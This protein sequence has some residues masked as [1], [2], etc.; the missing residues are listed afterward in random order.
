MSGEDGLEALAEAYE[1]AL[2]REKAGDAAGAAEGWRRVLALDPEDRGGAAVRLA[3]LGAEAAP[4]RAPP[5][6]VAELFDQH[7]EAFDD[8]LVRQL[9]YDAPAGLAALLRET[10]GAAAPAARALDL[11]CGTGLMAA[12]LEGLARAVDGVDLSEAMLAIADERGLYKELY[13]GDA[14][15][16]L[17]AEEAA[18]DGDARGGDAPAG[19]GAAG[20]SGGGDGDEHGGDDEDADAAAGP[21]D[22]ILA[23]DVLPYL[24]DLAPLAS[25]CARCLTPGGRLAL[26]SE[27]LPPEAI[28]PA[29]WTVGPHQ[30]FHHDPAYLARALEAEGFDIERLE[31]A[32]I[33]YNQGRPE[34][35]HLIVAR[36]SARAN[37]RRH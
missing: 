17:E 37:P 30:R 28:G 29:G 31:P 25:G 14:V 6:Y 19:D 21:W 36:L 3:A 16:F 5:A 35:G 24:G 26:S 12:A 9:G 32:V 8:I 23:A 27:T 11:G 7:A 20:A 4:D 10:M 33:R 2:A 22:L 13:V 1:A 18:A 15:A 34:H